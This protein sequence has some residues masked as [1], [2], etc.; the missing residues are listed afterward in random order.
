MCDA[1]PY[2]PNNTL[3]IIQAPEPILIFAQRTSIM[4]GTVIEL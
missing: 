2:T 1:L 4:D 3:T